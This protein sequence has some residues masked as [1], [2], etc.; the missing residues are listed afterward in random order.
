VQEDFQRGFVAAFALVTA[1]MFLRF[2]I[3][4]QSGTRCASV[5]EDELPGRGRLKRADDARERISPL[6]RYVVSGVGL[7]TAL[8]VWTSVLSPATGYAI[9]CLSLAIRA[10]G[11]LVAEE[12][13]PRRRSALIGR[14]RRVDVILLIW[15]AVAAASALSL[16]PYVL[17]VRDRV[18]AILVAA[19]VAAMLVVAWRIASAPPL[20]AGDDLDAEQIVDRETRAIRTGNAC[21]LAIAAVAAFNGFTGP[22]DVSSSNTFHWSVL[23]MLILAFGIFAWRSLYARHLSRTPLPS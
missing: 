12:R 14:S 2:A 15:I 7:G 22:A 3:A 21:F 20:L 17:E 18:A 5:S 16:L 8:A 6:P 11:D 9:M 10:L 13:A 19:C 4:A 1:V 23:A